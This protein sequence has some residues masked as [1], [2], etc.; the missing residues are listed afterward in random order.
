M[1][2]QSEMLVGCNSL[3]S[4]AEQINSVWVRAGEDT[5]AVKNSASDRYNTMRRLSVE[6]PTISGSTTIIVR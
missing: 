3:V 5:K 1:A 4:V 2:Q 6:Q